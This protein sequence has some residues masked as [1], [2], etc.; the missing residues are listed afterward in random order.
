MSEVLT[1]LL[2]AGEGYHTEFKQSLDK[3]FVEEACAF[4]NSGG[5]RIL[6]GVTDDGVI[7]GVDTGNAMRSRVQDM[8]SQIEPRLSCDTQAI[9]NVFLVISLKGRKSPMAV[10]VAFLCAWAPIRK[11]SPATRLSSFSRR[12][13]ASALTSSATAKRVTRRISTWKPFPDF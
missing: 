9:G 13:V 7:K 3:S 10:H 4:A 1:S 5:G 6:L 12:K 11:S 2:Q 8:L